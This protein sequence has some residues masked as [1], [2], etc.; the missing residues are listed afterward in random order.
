MRL[1]TFV[2]LIFCASLMLM[3]ID[4][5]PPQVGGQFQI[6]VR[7]NDTVDEGGVPTAPLTRS[8]GIIP[9]GGGAVVGC[10]SVPDNTLEYEVLA[11][12]AAT[13]VRQPVK[14]VAFADESC[15]GVPSGESENTAWT[16]PGMSPTPPNILALLKELMARIQ[17]I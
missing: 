12:L 14:A 17:R 5:Y 6:G 9:M 4:V 2:F 3:A 7:A 13:G 10:V 1:R 16:Y 8:I 15:S 11:D